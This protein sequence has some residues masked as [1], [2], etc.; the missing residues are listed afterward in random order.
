MITE[1]VTVILDDIND[2][3]PELPDLPNPAINIS[4]ETDKVRFLLNFYYFFVIFNLQNKFKL[5]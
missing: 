4:E 3:T 1:M 5:Y 2:Q